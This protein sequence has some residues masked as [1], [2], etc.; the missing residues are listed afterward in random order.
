LILQSH[1]DVVPEG[2]LD[3]WNYDPWGATIEN[4]KMY[5][6]GIQDMKSGMAAM[7]FAVRALQSLG[8]KPQGDIYLQSVIEEEITGNGALT[9]LVSGYRADAAL[10][11]EPFGQKGLIGQVGVVWL[12]VRVKGAAAHVER[13]S[14]AVNAIEKAY[15]LIH[16]IQKYRKHV[17]NEPKHPYFK[18]HPHPLNINI[19]KIHG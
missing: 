14:F 10:I 2:P 17:N 3:D 19:G 4:N 15:V 1:I 9:T 18:D 5:G 7:V 16:A 8:F 11:P 12:R 6:R 13:A